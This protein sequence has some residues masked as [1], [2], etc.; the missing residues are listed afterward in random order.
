MISFEVSETRGTLDVLY[1]EIDIPDVNVG[2]AADRG[3]VE[4]LSY[5]REGAARAEHRREA[6]RRARD[7]HDNARH[8]DQRATEAGGFGLLVLQRVL[9]AVEDVG[10]LLHSFAGD[11]PWERL[12]STRIPDLRT[13]FERAVNDVDQVIEEAFVLATDSQIA[14]E[15]VTPDQQAA[16]ARLGTLTRQRWV[17][18]LERVASWWLGH[19][20]VAKATMHGFPFVAGELVR[21]R[22]GAGALGA[23]FTSRTSPFAVAVTSKDRGIET[24]AREPGPDGESVTQREI[25][26]T[27]TPVGLAPSDVAH[28]DRTGR[29]AAHL[30]TELCRHHAESIMS[31]HIGGIP[32]RA[33]RYLDDTQQRAIRELWP[34]A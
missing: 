7:L 3:G 5:L 28:F 8:D 31:A 14:E 21:E 15:D 33:V 18:M 12:R 4:L 27:R 25:L 23:G 1:L 26:T 34:D 11:D 16:L 17:R 19:F 2:Y 10:V 20:N 22:P 13:A 9:F 6:I 32:M 24:I 30:A 29:I